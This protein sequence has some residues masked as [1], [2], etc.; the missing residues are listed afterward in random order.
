MANSRSRQNV[1]SCFTCLSTPSC[2]F[3]D[4]DR[5]RL[6]EL[7]KICQMRV[8]PDGAVL[9]A[10]GDQ[11]QGVLI[12][13]SG[14]VKLSIN[15]PDGRAVFTNIAT[16]GSIIGAE[17]MLTGK[18]HHL[19]AEAL[20]HTQLCF[21]KKEDFLDFLRRNADISVRLLQKLGSELYDSYPLL[22]EVLP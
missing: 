13:C 1:Q 8:Y 4:L 3:S 2:I 22:L 10:W 9:F 20:E 14:R 18:S 15:S 21:I 6:M 5:P 19:R 12:V 16:A 7:E 11:P 17:A